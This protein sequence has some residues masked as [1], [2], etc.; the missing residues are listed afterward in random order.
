MCTGRATSITGIHPGCKAHTKLVAPHA[1]FSHCVLHRY[2][3]AVKAHPP[4]ISEV[5]V[6]LLKLL[7]IFEAVLQ[8]PECLK[9]CVKNL[10]N[11]SVHF[12]SEQKFAGYRK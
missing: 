7:I 3:L 2:A 10:E 1:T 4:N 5:F 12:C 8:I 9:H 11:N 6:Q